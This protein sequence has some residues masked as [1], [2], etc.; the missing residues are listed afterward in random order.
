MTSNRTRYRVAIIGAGPGGIC[1][2]IKLMEAGIRDFVVLEKATG[3]G[4]TW[5]HNRYPGAECDVPSHLYSFS[6]EVKKDWS[7][8]Y[9]GQEEILEY[10]QH[11]AEKY[12][13]LPFVRFG[14][15][16]SRAHWQEGPARWELITESGQHI[17]ADAVISAIGMFNEL[18]YPDVPGLDSF[19]GHCFHSARWDHDHDLNGR[20][21]AVIG[22]A[23]SA[24][25]FV[26]EIAEKVSRLDLYQRTANWVLPKEDAPYTA[27]QLEHF[28]SHPTAVAE[29]RE[30]LYES[31]ENFITFSN[32]ETLAQA[33]AA[34]LENLQTVCDPELR[35]KLIPT[36]PFG[37][38]RPL[39]SNRFYPVFNMDHVH[40]ITDTIERITPRGVVSADGTERAVDTLILA[41]GFQTGRY[42]S[43]IEVTGRSERSLNDAWRD[44]AQAYLGIT[45]AG[46]PNLFMLYGPNTNNGSILYMLERQVDYALRRILQL[47]SESLAWI[48]V[49][50]AE[51]AQY[52]AQLQQ[53]IDK[54]EVWQA[55]CSGYYRAPSGRV[56]TQWPHTM[57]EF[58][59][60]TSRDD[61]AAYETAPRPGARASSR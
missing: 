13:V 9:A 10:M 49:R 50:E 2:A 56:V 15:A 46:F 45:T 32:P 14:D 5:W 6:F 4:G 24:V 16:V 36:H 3:V 37:C 54:V 42:L 60:R 31:L 30:E 26:P 22:S 7:R 33:E 61:S 52:N 1:S 11:C 23:A 43:A 41:T 53:D 38:K 25:Q 29:R 48:D 19:A 17:E 28:R 39:A 35:R 27:Q 57:A 47:E 18:A 59:A 58:S 20:R 34:G 21:V 44:G 40:L 55:G 8:P 12:G 51:M